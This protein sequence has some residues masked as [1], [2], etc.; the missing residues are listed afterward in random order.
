MNKD[1]SP[2]SYFGKTSPEFHSN[3]PFSAGS[4][5]FFICFLFSV[6]CTLFFAAC[7]TT[8]NT[9]DIKRAEAY[10][11]LGVSYLKNGQ[12]NQAYVEFQKAIG[13][14]PKN[15]ETL[16][17]LG[18]INA[19]YKKYDEAIEHYKRAISID[20]NY[21]DAMNNLGI[22]YIEIG[23]WNEAISSFTGALKNPLY[24]TPERAYTSMGYAYYMNGDYHKAENA[25]K[26]AMMRNP[27]YPLANYTLG[28]VY[29]KLSDDEKAIN[30]FTKAIAI[31]PDY[32]SAHWELAQIYL[33]IGA[34]AKALKHFGIV[35]EKDNDMERS[36]MAIDHIKKLKY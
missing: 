2:H 27:V 29:V 6:F 32:I 28:L 36:K 8:P 12:T 25:L 18:Y 31:S 9:K 5:V 24:N 34:N 19:L 1:I 10:N 15:K 23:K 26:E 35:A 16:N 4:N 20:P 33:R 22:L 7:A 14:N 11:T 17:Y 21:S 3:Y 30:E 13:L